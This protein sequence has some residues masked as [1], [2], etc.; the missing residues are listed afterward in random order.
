MRTLAVF[1]YTPTLSSN[2]RATGSHWRG[3]KLKAVIHMETGTRI[4]RA[5]DHSTDTFLGLPHD[6]IRAERIC[7]ADGEVMDDKWFFTYGSYLYYVRDR[8]VVGVEVASAKI[9]KPGT[10]PKPLK[11]TI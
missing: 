6:Y 3:H 1:L 9:T 7:R 2:R 4:Y 8:D 5:S 11:R 10:M